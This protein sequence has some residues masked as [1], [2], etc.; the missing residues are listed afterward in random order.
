[1]GRAGHA[2]PRRCTAQSP[3]FQLPCVHQHVQ[4]LPSKG[5]A[6]LPRPPFAP[7]LNPSATASPCGDERLVLLQRL[8]DAHHPLP[9]VREHDDAAA[10]AA[11]LAPSAGALQGRVIG[12]PARQAPTRVRESR[13]GSATPGNAA[14]TGQGLP[15]GGQ[16]KLQARED[17]SPQ[18]GPAASL[19]TLPAWGWH[20]RCAPQSPGSAG[21][22]E[23]RAGRQVDRVLADTA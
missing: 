19:P 17:G 11:A 6:D 1:M 10:G 18:S 8:A 5:P 2:E 9:E 23:G 4:G 15:A 7:S 12:W 3:A 22:A 20:R 21:T 14:R 16:A 13:R